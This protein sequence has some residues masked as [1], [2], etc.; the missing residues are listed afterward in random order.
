MSNSSNYKNSAVWNGVVGNIT[1]VGTNGSPSYYGTRDQSG[2]IWE[3]IENYNSN[4]ETRTRRGGAWNS[5]SSSSISVSGV[6][7]T[8]LDIKSH[9][10]GFRI[11]QTGNNLSFSHFVPINNSFNVSDTG[12]GTN[13]GAV[14]YNYQIMM[15]PVT[16]EEYVNF[17]NIVDPS[18]LNNNNLYSSLM[19]KLED[20]SNN[21]RGGINLIPSNIVGQKYT[22][23]TYF[24]NKP[25]NYISWKNAAML[26][27]WLHNGASHSSSVATGVY[28]ISSTNIQRAYN[29]SYFIPNDNEWYKSAFYSSAITGY[30]LYATQSNSE[31]CAIGSNSCGSVNIV[32]GSGSILNSEPSLSPTPT[33][34]L[35]PTA[36]PTLTP[37]ITVSTSITP[38]ITV[39]PTK[40]PTHTPTTSISPT[41]TT[42]IGAS[43][44]PTN[45][46]TISVTPTITETPTNTP[47]TTPTISITPT[48]TVTP[49]LTA[50]SSVT[51][52]KTATVTPTAS[53]TP[54]ISLTPSA[55]LISSNN[56]L[57]RLY[58]IKL[59]K[60]KNS[61][62]LLDAPAP[63]YSG[64]PMVKDWYNLINNIELIY[65]DKDIN[66]YYFN[67]ITNIS[68]TVPNKDSTIKELVPD[69]TYYFILKTD[70]KLPVKIPSINYRTNIASASL[71][72][73]IKK[74][75]FPNSFISKILN[76]NEISYITIIDALHKDIQNLKQNQRYSSKL[77]QAKILLDMTNKEY[78]ENDIC[79]KLT[80][81]ETEDCY[82]EYVWSEN[83]EY[84]FNP[85][86]NLPSGTN[87]NSNEIILQD[88]DKYLSRINIPLNNLPVL[89]DNEEITY[90]FKI[91][92]SDQA[93]DI[94]PASGVIVSSS[95]ES[96]ISA[97]LNLMPTPTN[98]PTIS[99]TP[100]LTPT[101][102]TTPTVTASPTL[103]RTPTS[104]STPTNTP[105]ISA[106]P[107]V[108][109]TITV[110][111]TPTISISATATPTVTPTISETPTN[112]PTST[113]TPTISI[114]QT[115]T[116]TV[117]PT[118]SET[119]TNTPTST[120]TPTVS[121]SETA[122]P[123]PTPTISETPTNTPTST[124][125]PTP[126]QT[127]SV[128]P[129]VTPTQG[130]GT[131]SLWAWG[132]NTLGRLGLGDSIERNIPSAILS[133]TEWS[134]VS[135]GATHTL[136]IKKD[137]TLW[138]W[139]ANNSFQLGDN[140]GFS[141]SIPVQIGS[142]QI[143]K[144]IAAGETYSLGITLNNLLYVWG[145]SSLYQLGNS[146]IQRYSPTLIS[147]TNQYLKVAAGKY[148]SMAINANQEIEAA[149][150][151][152]YQQLI[153]TSVYY[154]LWARVFTNI[155]VVDISLGMSHSLFIT[156]D[157]DLYSAG[158]NSYGQ[159]GRVTGSQNS[160]D[161]NAAQVVSNNYNW[162]QVTAGSFHSLA[163]RED[164]TLWAFGR[165]TDGQLGDGTNSNRVE[166][167]QVDPG[168]TWKSVAAGSNH[169]YGIKTDGTLW[170]WGLNINNQ[171]GIGNTQSSNIP[172]LVSNLYW[173]GL[174]SGGISGESSFAI[175]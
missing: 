100:T 104:T 95:N 108:T 90:E 21:P 140:T 131:G 159:L 23:K 58:N 68:G 30:Y 52:T 127:I 13:L 17:L 149:G 78:R 125:T 84:S 144:E 42:S 62:N 155:T 113:V 33:M 83:S 112:T 44:T 55:D 98:T 171:L 9:N 51:P 49:T 116:P 99:I 139:G 137:G 45:T 32:T 70:S 120:V 81:S 56:I 151:N 122:T 156:N 53:V 164:N 66:N 22:V 170:A 16:N 85:S 69:H 135:A 101:I 94:Y 132:S 91:I 133:N 157:G 143:W 15:D 41:P 145:N 87:N 71:I 142:G 63:R 82:S 169:S 75:D 46:P 167:V 115:A 1:S 160:Y 67:T 29:A 6:L 77:E 50:T 88:V 27:N 97:I 24:N 60:G 129:T 79:S 103:T 5:T 128:T 37:T 165:N 136:A 20:G 7:Y 114:S 153:G 14:D 174:A 118:I 18:G 109:P 54:T 89:G 152:P 147:T 119:P 173:T 172:V 65:S 40:T 150:Y 31:P 3:W 2:N 166:M 4:N 73:A 19:S 126:T 141:R 72:D 74:L 47:T 25:A 48:R 38:T 76:N 111:V 105:T 138:A 35:S 36:T 80:I 34:S 146:G 59:Y 43:A 168:S 110:T 161:K 96:N 86:I 121:V 61:L 10:T 106:T 162:K 175:R 64:D 11:A 148:S 117:T 92:D 158:N 28:D 163:I 39:T 124:V 123:T 12:N 107:T 154:T 57:D 93:Y 8:N 134:K 26:C 102:S 130:G